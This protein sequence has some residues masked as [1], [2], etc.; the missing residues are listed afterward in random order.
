[1]STRLFRSAFSQEDN[2]PNVPEAIDPMKAELALESAAVEISESGF[3]VQM[4]EFQQEELEHAHASLESIA[5]SLESLLAADERGLDRVSAEGYQ[6]AVTAILGDSLPNPVASLESFG[7]ESECAEATQMSMEGIKDTLQKIWQGIK[8]SIENAI[9]ATSDFFAKLFGGVKKLQDR[10][11]SMKQQVAE[12]QK[13]DAK[14]GDKF[15][16][17]GANAV[18]LGGDVSQKVLEDGASTVMSQVS[19]TA[20]ALQ[21]AAVDYYK[22]LVDFYSKKPD[23]AEAL[24]GEHKKA[25]DKIEKIKISTGE[26]PGG[27]MFEVE[28]KTKGDMET[29]GVPKLVDFPSKKNVNDSVELEPFDLKWIEKMLDTAGKFTEEMSKKQKR[30]EDLKSARQD[31][32]KAAEQFVG[33]SEKKLSDKW[34]QAKLN[35]AM[36]SANKDFSSTIARVDGYV[37]SYVRALLAVLGAAVSA[38]GAASTEEDSQEGMKKD[39]EYSKEEDDADEKDGDAEKD[40][41]DEE[42]EESKKDGKKK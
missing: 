24:E 29:V 9:R 39:D 41:D 36:K 26:L 21:E 25:A 17:P 40:G 11:A 19:G 1:M 42:S 35:W 13:A 15:K 8:R 22:G 20:D 16:V 37:F 31:T 12:K 30:R 34:N 14:A 27:K 6:H 18:Q 7:G 32:M 3:E 4:A 5:N 2:Q 33:D 38:Y 23:D 10:I 28:S